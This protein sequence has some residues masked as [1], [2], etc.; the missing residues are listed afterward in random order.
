[1]KR[2][3]RSNRDTSGEEFKENSTLSVCFVLGSVFWFS[4]RKYLE[5]SSDGLS[6]GRVFRKIFTKSTRPMLLG[7]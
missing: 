3:E 5:W 2:F 6:N 1:M 7:V 4:E